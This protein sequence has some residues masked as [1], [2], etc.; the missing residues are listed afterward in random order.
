[1]VSIAIKNGDTVT[2]TFENTGNGAT[3]TQGFWAT[4]PQ[5]A[6]IA[7]NGGTEFGHTFPGVAATPGIGDKTL[8][9]DT[10][11]IDVT[12]PADGRQSELMGG[13]W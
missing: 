5:L 3:R 1:M 7:W 4:H 10:L 8:C 12:E 11:T 2:C 13:F 6:K 9:S